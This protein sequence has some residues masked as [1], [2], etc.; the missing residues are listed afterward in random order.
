MVAVSK[1]GQITFARFA[2]P[3]PSLAARLM[4]GLPNASAMFMRGESA[5]A[6]MQRSKP[7]LN[8]CPDRGPAAAGVPSPA[9]R[10]FLLLANPQEE[11]S[12]EHTSELQS[13]MYLVCRLLLEKKKKL[14]PRNHDRPSKFLSVCL[15]VLRSL[16]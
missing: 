16:L 13:P 1:G 6:R 3:T 9:S 15:V 5:P 7:A 2:G 4:I 14:R 8:R 12:E 10:L 11:R